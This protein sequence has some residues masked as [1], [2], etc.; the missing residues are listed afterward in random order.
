MLT[1]AIVALPLSVSAAE[2]TKCATWA[3]VVAAVEADSAAS[4]KLTNHVTANSTIASFAGTFD[5]NGY[6][7]TVEK[8][9]FTALANGAVLKNFQTTAAAA[10]SEAPIAV[11]ASGTVTFTKKATGKSFVSV[12]PLGE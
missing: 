6:T 4:I 11:T 1:T 5:G 12:T 10:I 3:D 2:A 7:V 9:M 8:T